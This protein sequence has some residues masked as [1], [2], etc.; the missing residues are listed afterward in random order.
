MIDLRHI[1]TQHTR[2]GY[3]LRCPRCG[4]FAPRLLIVDTGELICKRCWRLI[5]EQVDALSLPIIRDY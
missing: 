2:R 1:E 4:E 3:V 5:G